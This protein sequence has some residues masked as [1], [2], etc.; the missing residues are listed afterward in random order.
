MKESKI[1][2][3]SGL[4]LTASVSSSQLLVPS[5][6]DINIGN[7]KLDFNKNNTVTKMS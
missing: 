6:N 2:I 3:L 4:L 5:N 1:I 7:T